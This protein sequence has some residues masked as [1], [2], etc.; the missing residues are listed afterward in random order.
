MDIAGSSSQESDKD[1][2]PKGSKGV[3][4]RLIVDVLRYWKK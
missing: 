2:N 1:Y 4:V 3:A